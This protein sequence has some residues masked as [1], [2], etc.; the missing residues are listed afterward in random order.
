[1]TG[2][3]IFAIFLYL[4]VLLSIVI[5][6]TITVGKMTGTIFGI[7]LG[8][9]LSTGAILFKPFREWLENF[10]TENISFGPSKPVSDETKKAVVD[11]YT[12][13]LERFPDQREIQKYGW[14]LHNEESSIRDVIRE[15][16][17]S[18]EYFLKFVKRPVKP[19]QAIVYF[20][21]HF[22]GREP[23]TDNVVSEYIDLMNKSGK[24]G[25]KLVVDELINSNEYIL[26]FGDYSVPK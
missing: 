22:L 10:T 20:Y 16:G 24:D 7:V 3:G 23:E 14:R 2:K 15:V 5:S 18:N 25:W 4:L 1:M 19:E 9:I 26:N 8:A 11:I 13:V 12:Q 17:K 21:K 6:S